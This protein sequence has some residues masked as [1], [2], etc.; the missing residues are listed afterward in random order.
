[1]P[2]FYFDA[3][4]GGQFCDPDGTELAD[5]AAAKREAYKILCQLLPTKAGHVLENGAFV[6]TVSDADRLVLMR[7]ELSTILSPAVSGGR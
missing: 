3:E 6:L 5:F 1:M 7:L 4:D 2:R